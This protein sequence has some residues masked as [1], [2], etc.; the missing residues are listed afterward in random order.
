M[1]CIFVGDAALYFMRDPH[2]M[3][4]DS[5]ELRQET[6][7]DAPVATSR[8]NS[9]LIAILLL[10]IFF[11]A[12]RWRLADTPLERDEGEYAYAGQLMLQGIPPYKLA[13][14]MKLPGTYACYAVI[15]AA[16][17]ETPRG[18]HLGV[19]L[20]NAAAILFIY[21][22]A[23]QLLGPWSA[24]AAAAAYALLSTIPATLGL[25][26][27]AT[28]FVVFAAV[29][30]L[31]L[32]L[33]AEV[34]EQ[35]WLYFCSGILFGLA[36]IMKQ[37]GVFF[38]AFGFFYILY[39]S[40]RAASGWK[41]LVVRS[42][43]F[44]AGCALPFLITCFL[45]W[46]SGVFGDFWFWTFSYARQ[47]SGLL[48]FKDGWD[49]FTYHFSRIFKAA[50]GLWILALLGIVGLFWH[51]PL[52]KRAPFVLGLLVFS[53]FGVSAGLYFR[54]HYFLLAV[55]AIAL[56]VGLAIESFIQ[57]LH[58][59]RLAF[60]A[61]PFA[62]FGVAL[63][64]SVA[65]NFG[66]YFRL[67]P[68]QACRYAYGMNEGFP[69]AQQIAR[70][71]EQHTLPGDRIGVLGSEPEIYFDSHRV[72]ATGY[73]YLYPL[74][75][76]QPYWQKMQERLMAEVEASHPAYF[77]YFNDANSWLTTVSSARLPG[78]FNWANAYLKQNYQRV[79]VVELV[80][81]EPIFLWG[82]QAESASAKTTI[83]IFKRKS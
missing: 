1:R 54:F 65:L 46:R 44:L 15:M 10:V 30:A 35:A 31:I 26:G 67:T 18:I 16:L 61:I 68:V 83:T 43:V 34:H 27:H 38:G 50:P 57:A 28:H 39:F 2:L 12:V 53:M 7:S 14:N 20:G 63:L 66:Y 11:S 25:A 21:L 17:G 33:W 82:D 45:M 77:V 13:Y 23:L 51:E 78:F 72:S 36:F 59:A 42:A 32:L 56:L 5:V 8:F 81:P 19:M 48:T 52:R 40:L 70:Y 58:G 6:M 64:C 29:P 9:S 73:I 69:E 74:M 24:V 47:Y 75:E 55:P 22:L 4:V 62:I 76:N 71:L 49:L 41:R 80:E 37:P 60:R 79:G 3:S